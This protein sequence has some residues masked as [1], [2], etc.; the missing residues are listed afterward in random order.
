MLTER[1]AELVPCSGWT[2]RT[3]VEIVFPPRAC[4]TLKVVGGVVDFIAISNMSCLELPLDA[5][6]PVIGVEGLGGV[7]ENRGMKPD[8]VIQGHQLIMLLSGVVSYDFQQVMRVSVVPL[9]FHQD[10]GHR[11]WKWK[12]TSFRIIPTLVA[13][14]LGTSPLRAPEGQDQ[15]QTELI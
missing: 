9:N 7:A 10:L 6:E 3:H 12:F 13:T 2:C 14:Q 15:C 1:S 11:G 8:E 5:A 4:C